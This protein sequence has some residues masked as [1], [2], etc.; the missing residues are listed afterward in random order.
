MQFRATAAK[1]STTPLANVQKEAQQISKDLALLTSEEK[2][3]KRK[4]QNYI[5]IEEPVRTRAAP[6]FPRYNVNP[7]F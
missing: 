5:T 3:Q 2:E 6:N 7:L 4:L 1:F